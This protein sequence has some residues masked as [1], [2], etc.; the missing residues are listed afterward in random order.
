MLTPGALISAAT[1]WTRP[2][3]RGHGLVDE[4]VHA[5]EP[6][7]GRRAVPDRLA[8][9][10]PTAGRWRPDCSR[11]RLRGGAGGDELAAAQRGP[12][13]LV[14]GGAQRHPGPEGGRVDADHADRAAARGD[15]GAVEGDHV[16]H[17]G[18]L[19]RAGRCR[20]R[21]RPR[22]ATI[23][24]S[25]RMIRRNDR[26]WAALPPWQ[27]AWLLAL[28]G[29]GSA[30]PGGTRNR[31]ACC[32]ASRPCASAAPADRGTAA[33]RPGRVRPGRRRPRPTPRR[34]SWPSPARAGGMQAPQRGDRG[35]DDSGRRCA[36]R[37]GGALAPG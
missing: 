20:W 5:V 11:S 27:A 23:S 19:A 31:A 25:G 15:L 36:G 3:L 4:Q 28:P 18:D 2:S 32:A 9:R 10:R 24:R 26:A 37:G 6:E 17:A 8:G 16:A 7:P 1:W 21:V 30:P 35:L 34:R 29:L 12:E 13:R 33:G 22:G 14:R